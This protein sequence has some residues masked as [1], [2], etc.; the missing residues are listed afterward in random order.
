MENIQLGFPGPIQ[1][2][3]LL[4]ILTINSHAW[5]WER[6]ISPLVSTKTSL[7]LAIWLV[8][9][10]LWYH[11]L[12]SEIVKRNTRHKLLTLEDNLTSVFFTKSNRICFS[13][14]PELIL[15]EKY[16]VILTTV[17]HVSKMREQIWAPYL[18][19]SRS[20]NKENHVFTQMPA[21]P[22]TSAETTLHELL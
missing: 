12:S 3:Q 1:L 7:K 6:K 20:E 2:V 9:D 18:K 13:K 10:T 5:V 11:I 8:S 22:S 15:S 16:Q 21:F 4:N 19:I 14:V 17:F